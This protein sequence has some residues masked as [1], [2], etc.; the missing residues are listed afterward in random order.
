MEVEAA[1][2]AFAI[3]VENLLGSAQRL[4]VDAVYLGLVWVRE[5]WTKRTLPL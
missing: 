4:V 3:L 5:Q 1:L 2:F